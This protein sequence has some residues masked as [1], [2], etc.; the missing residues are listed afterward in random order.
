[1]EKLS[2]NIQD[3]IYTYTHQIKFKNVMNELKE[4]VN[5][6][7]NEQLEF[8]Y[9]KGRHQIIYNHFKNKLKNLNDYDERLFINL[10]SNIVLDIIKDRYDIFEDFNKQNQ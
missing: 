3:I 7:C 2:D 6:W 1:M 9:C 5:Y 10:K 4:T 8:T